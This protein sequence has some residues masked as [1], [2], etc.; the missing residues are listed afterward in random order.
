MPTSKLEKQL[1]KNRRAEEKAEKERRNREYAAEI[2]RP[3]PIINDLKVLDNEAEEMLKAIL[4]QYDGNENNYVKFSFDG[5]SRPLLDSI[6]IQFEKL[7]MYGMVAQAITY[8]YGG[9]ITLTNSAKTYFDRK[10]EA[11]LNRETNL[12][13]IN[14]ENTRRIFIVHGHDEEAKLQVARFLEHGGFEPII[15][16]E[17]PNQGKTVIEKFETY[18]DVAF[19][20]ILYT[21]CDIG[22]DKTKSSDEDKFRARQNVVLEHGYFMGKLGRNRV[23]ALV[24]GDVEIPSDYAGVLYEPMDNAGAWRQSIAKEMQAAGLECDLNKMLG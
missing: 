22:R 14:P 18:S 7:K 1:E 17:Q 9:M 12:K 10:E 3:Q 23:V 5:L 4:N 6:A 20:I 24:K 19:A 8:G 21:E 16:H 13:R 2:V 11:L 15:L